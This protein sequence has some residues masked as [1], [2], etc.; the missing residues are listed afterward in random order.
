MNEDVYKINKIKGGL[1]EHHL[2]VESS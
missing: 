2:M 1:Q